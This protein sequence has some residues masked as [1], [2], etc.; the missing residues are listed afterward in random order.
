[1]RERDRAQVFLI[2]EGE[3][4][5]AWMKTEPRVLSSNA[6]A[7]KLASQ[8]ERERNRQALAADC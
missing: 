7:I 3:L 5:F 6:F 8:A 2:V 4:E 1:M